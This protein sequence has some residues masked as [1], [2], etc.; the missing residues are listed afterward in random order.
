M[1]RVLLIENGI[2]AQIAKSR[3]LSKLGFK[4]FIAQNLDEACRRLQKQSIDIV[5]AR[6]DVDCARGLEIINL[7]KTL[8]SKAPIIIYACNASIDEAVKAIKLGAYEYFAESEFENKIKDVLIRACEYRKLLVPEIYDEDVLKQ[9][10]NVVS[11]SPL[12]SKLARRVLKVAPTDASVLIYG[13]SGTGKELIARNIHIHSLRSHKK[14]I[15]VDLVAFPS[16][17]IES[18][19]FGYEKG[20]FTGAVKSKPG[21]FELA[22]GGTLFLDEITELDYD[23]QAKLLRVIQERKIRKLGST[24]VRSVDVRLI[25]A[26]NRN[27]EDA[28][29]DKV[30]REDLYYRLNVVPLYVPPLRERKEDIPLLVKHFIQKYNASIP[31]KIEGITDEALEILQSYHWPGNIRELENVVQQS[32]CICEGNVIDVEPLLE[33]IE[34]GVRLPKKSS[35]QMSFK[36]AQKEYLRRFNKIYFQSL[37][38]RYHGN[39]SQIAREAGLCRKTV[40]TILQETGIK[41]PD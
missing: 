20:A 39:I 23:L 40:Y 38:E 37:M 22:D 32:M 2:E 12:M 19:L 35:G 25:S 1:N 10:E 24:K 41:I 15:P 26:T 13:E 21:L 34:L 11:T 29:K 16:T 3:F 5:V 28:I 30:L 31:G 4:C 36:K 8:D 14:F 27:P 7:L 18:E 9:L 6:S 33:Y 17:L